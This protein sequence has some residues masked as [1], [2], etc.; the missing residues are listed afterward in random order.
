MGPEIKIVIDN[1]V[2]T[3]NLQGQVK[4]R[5]MRMEEFAIIELQY[6]R[7]KKTLETTY[8]TDRTLCAMVRHTV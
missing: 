1:P 4:I 2:L 8:C 5:C 7:E 6:K 3:E